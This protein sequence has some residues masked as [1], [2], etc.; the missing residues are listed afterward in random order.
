MIIIQKPLIKYSNCS[1]CGSVKNISAIKVGL[2]SKGEMPLSFSVLHLC[3]DCQKRLI[4]ELE[5]NS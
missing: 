3:V 1:S 5:K 2:A 4:K